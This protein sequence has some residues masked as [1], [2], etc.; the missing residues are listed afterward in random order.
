M[1]SSARLRDVGAFGTTDL[2]FVPAAAAA[3]ATVV[4]DAIDLRQTSLRNYNHLVVSLQAGGVTGGPSAAAATLIVETSDASDFGSGVTTLADVDGSTDGVSVAAEETNSA[5]A[6]YDLSGADRYVRV[7]IT[8][9]LTGGSSPTM[10]VAASG[11]LY[12]GEL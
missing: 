12:S 9:D 5:N 8:N 4:G 3:T 11:F 2:N 1:A 7:S 6:R 10:V